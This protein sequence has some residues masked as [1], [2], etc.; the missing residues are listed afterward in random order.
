MHVARMHT[1]MLPGV[2]RASML[3]TAA[4]V[5]VPPRLVLTAET[6]RRQSRLGDLIE[7]HGLPEWSA[8][9]LFLLE[10][11]RN[12]GRGREELGRDA[13]WGPWLQTLPRETG[14]VLEWSQSEARTASATLI[15]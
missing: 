11:R 8:L 2:F 10:L 7:A 1:H 6:A 13:D 14:C 12:G 5:Q 4:R 3:T 15:V 9:A